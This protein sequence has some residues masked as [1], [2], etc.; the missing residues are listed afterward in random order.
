MDVTT[1]D[2][3]VIQLSGLSYCFA[4]AAEIAGAWEEAAATTI[5]AT[6]AVSGSSSYCSAVV[7]DAETAVSNPTRK[8]GL[9]PPFSML[10][11]FFHLY[12]IFNRLLI[13]PTISLMTFA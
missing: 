6:I 1:T 5:A 3:D 11:S 4:A 2:V 13:C 7:V 8:R 12:Y 10:I 9:T